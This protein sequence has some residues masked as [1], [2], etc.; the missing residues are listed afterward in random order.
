[1]SQ[2]KILKD[3]SNEFKP[4]PKN[5]LIKNVLVIDKSEKLNETLNIIIQNGRIS[6]ILKQPP[7]SFN[8]EIIENEDSVIMPGLIDMHVH[9]R[10]PGREDEETIITGSLAA[11]NGGFTS[12]ACMPNTIPVNDNQS[13]T[14]FILEKA[15]T[16]SARVYLA[17]KW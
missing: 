3:E 13:V 16:A 10:E 8:G 7:D 15:E 6:D 17:R 11:A 14:R 5:I 1:M 9:L 12:I 2:F 4:V